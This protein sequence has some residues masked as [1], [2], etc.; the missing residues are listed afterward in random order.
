MDDF[1]DE[2]SKDELDDEKPED[3]F[4]RPHFKGNTVLRPSREREIRDAAARGD[5][6]TLEKYAGASNYPK[7]QKLAQEELDRL[8]ARAQRRKSK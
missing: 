5:I 8:A 1:D 6:P 4:V 2:S 7:H 3:N